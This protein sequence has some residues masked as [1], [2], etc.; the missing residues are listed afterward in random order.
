VN[1]KIKQ[2]Y[3]QKSQDMFTKPIKR[4]SE[5]SLSTGCSR[6]VCGKLGEPQARRDRE[7]APIDTAEYALAEE[8]KI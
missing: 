4:L 7:P 2:N 3:N 1:A 8:R 6:W 5:F